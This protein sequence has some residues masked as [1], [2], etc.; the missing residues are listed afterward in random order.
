MYIT[1][2]RLYVAVPK[3]LV[4]QALDDDGVAGVDSGRWDEVAA[5]VQAAIDGPLSQRYAT[6]FADDA[7]PAWISHAALVF[8]A[9]LIYQRRGLHGDE[10]NPWT[11]RAD[12]L[13]E[14]LADIAAGKAPLGGAYD[15][16]QASAI[17]IDQDCRTYT[18]SGRMMS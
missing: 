2:A 6:P 3:P 12:K 4:D 7:T 1:L 10:R 14:Q 9:E 5:E 18:E 11:R 13:R 17:V 8:A 16:E 15:R